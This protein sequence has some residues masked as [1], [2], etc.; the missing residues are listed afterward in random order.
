VSKAVAGVLGVR[1]D[2][3]GLLDLD[4]TTATY[5]AGLPAHHQTHTVRQTISNRSG[6]G[7]HSTYSGQYTN[8]PY[9]TAQE[10]VDDIEDVALA[11][12]T[13]DYLYS[14]PAFT[15]EGAA[16]EAVTGQA[17][18]NALNTYLVAP[19]T[20]NTLRSMHG[21]P[22]DANRATGYST[23]NQE[24]G[25]Y[26]ASHK[27]LGGGLESSAY[28]LARMGIKLIDGQVLA[29]A[30][31]DDMWDAP[32]S[33]STFALG[34]TENV[35]FSTQ[36]VARTGGQDGANTHIRMYPDKDVV[37]VVLSNRWKGGH[38]ATKLGQEIGALIIAELDGAA[39]A[40][41]DGQRSAT[42]AGDF[43]EP[44][45]EATDPALVTFPVI[46]NPVAPDPFS[47]E[48]YPEEYEVTMQAFL[49]LIG[50]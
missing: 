47:G 31:L 35:E 44:D 17:V 26:E 4:A 20:L 33:Q 37:I 15:F 39:Q 29:Q 21:K 34:W 23:S 5:V 2:Q 48:E 6:I 3:L 8:I 9:D 27:V 49:P 18:G 19:F 25:V 45:D 7:H 28:D 36:V 30:S 10:T 1:L 11:T 38:S 46:T 16:I 12:T 14:S 32:D 41:A 42:A 24:L 43:E 40:A 13:G 50:K 22:P